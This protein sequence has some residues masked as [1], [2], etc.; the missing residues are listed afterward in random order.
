MKLER[1]TYSPGSVADFF[2]EALG[3]L[4]ALCERT[5]HDR[6]QVVAEDNAA[7]LWNADGALVEKEIFFPSPDETAPRQADHEVFPDARL[8]SGWWNR[9]LLAD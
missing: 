7:R 8:R 3:S 1:L 2:E 4:G 6:L 9:W 5:W